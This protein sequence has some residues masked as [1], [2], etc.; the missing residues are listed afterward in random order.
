MGLRLPRLHAWPLPDARPLPLP[1]GQRASAL[2]GSP[3]WGRAARTQAWAGGSAP[4][5]LMPRGRATAAGPQGADFPSRNGPPSPSLFGGF[6]EGA[7]SLPPLC[8]FRTQSTASPAPRRPYP[9]GL[10]MGP[11]QDHLSAGAYEPPP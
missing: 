2:P 6:S 11:L 4:R 5:W 10:F 3:T 7:A 8:P 1:L 9:E